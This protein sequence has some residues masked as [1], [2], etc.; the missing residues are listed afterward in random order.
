[1]PLDLY[2]RHS[3]NCKYSSKGQNYTKCTCVIWC[4]GTLHGRPVRETMKTRDW[5]IA[6]RNLREMELQPTGPIRVVTVADAINEYL[7]DCHARKLAPST[8]TSYETLLTAFGSYCERKNLREVR[9]LRLE[10]FRGF[11]NSRQVANTTQRK[12]IEHL[13]SFCN[14][15]LEHEWIP[16]NFARSLKPPEKTGPVT[17]P[18][19]PEE[20]SKLLAAC[21]LITNANVTTIERSRKRARA[22][23]LLMLYGGLR[24]SDA[25]QLERA[26]LGQDGRLRMRQMKTGNWLYVKLHPDC[27]EALRAL[28]EES[29]YFL[30][31]GKSKISTA[32]GSARRTVECIS[33]IAKVEAR[34]HRFR[35]TF[36]VELLLADEDIRTV[37][38]LLGHA[39]VKTT[40]EHYAPFVRRFQDKLDAAT[41]K[42]QFGD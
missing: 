42:L 10:D 3:S 17:L 41:T 38:L 4:Y 14:F 37:Q 8:I 22:L 7:D 30:W 28:P 20:I 2:R 16:K 23:V 11:R 26:R 21:D 27:V 34:P 19:E 32:T 5:T 12:E 15:C 13:R 35:D 25:V 36:A 6:L 40:E 33:K 24:V 31:S 1:M 18:Y 9:G 39:S 29:P